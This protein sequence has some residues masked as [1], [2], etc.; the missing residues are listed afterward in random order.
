MV[1]KM[2]GESMSHL[3]SSAGSVEQTLYYQK[4]PGEDGGECGRFPFLFARCGGKN[5]SG[6][7]IG[8]WARTLRSQSRLT[9]F[10]PDL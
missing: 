10:D 1:G 9:T 3:N 5:L 6:A 2:G 8:R 7:L 4:R